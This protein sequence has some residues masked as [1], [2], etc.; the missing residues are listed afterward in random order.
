[1]NFN[2]LLKEAYFY[3]TAVA[4]D[5][6]F[7]KSVRVV[8]RYFFLMLAFASFAASFADFKSASYN[9]LPDGL[10]FLFLSLFIIIFLTE[11]FYNSFK[12]QNSRVDF[13]LAQIILKTD[14]LDVTG[15]FL[16]SDATKGLLRRLGIEKM[17]G[18]RSALLGS[19][20]KT[21]E[22]ATRSQI[23]FADYARAIYLADQSFAAFI[24]GHGVSESDYLGA[25]RWIND[26]LIEARKK[27]QWWSEVNLGAIPSLGTSLAYGV[28]YELSKY[29][30]PISKII[31]LNE[32][33]ILNQYRKKEVEQIENALVRGSGANAIIIDNDETAVLDIVAR[34][35]KKIHLGTA[36]SLLEHKI[37]LRLNW[38]ALT[39]DKKTKPDLEEELLKV[40]YECARAGNIILYIPNLPSLISEAQKTG[41][42]LPGLMEEYLVSPALHILAHATKT[43][44]YYFIEMNPGLG[45]VFER[46]ALPETDIESSMPVI[47]E[48]AK[49]IERE[50]RGA[51]FFTYP[52]LAEIAELSDRYI[53]YGEMPSK[54]LDMMEELAPW[55][56]KEGLQIILKND[57]AVFASL[58]TGQSLGEISS[59][60]SAKL[61]KLEEILH[62]RIV[63]QEEAVNAISSAMRRSRAG[64]GNPKRPIASF[65]FL[66]PTGVGKTETTKAL[67]QSYFGPPAGE[68]EKMTRFDM[69]EYNGVDAIP[70]L[71]GSMGFARAG[72]L[73]TK[74]RDNPYGVVLLDEF[75][76]AAPD[77]LNLFLR[78][79][80]EGKFTDAFGGEVSVRNSI[81]IATSNAGSDLIWNIVKNHEDVEQ[82]KD[83]IIEYLIESH[84]FKPELL[85]R[86]DA[87]I[88]F[89]PLL[90]TELRSVAQILL[91]KFIMRL[92]AEKQIELK[93]SSELLD[94]LVLHGADREFGAR[95]INRLIQEKIENAIAKKIIS[96]QVHPGSVIEIGV[97]DIL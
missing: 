6:L 86:F 69:S 25:A 77:V 38:R 90:D 95:S 73:A 36:P 54:A 35:D 67:A 94:Y 61:S 2:E 9:S 68:E 4:L 75:E 56:Q 79:L 93:P 76:K 64:I 45:Q 88:I 5:N 52:A 91:Q 43:D 29:A 62:Q 97:R 44:F 41:V 66:G 20:F 53:A 16:D 7:P 58:K 92:K 47:L 50:S 24:Q 55:A 1:M 96:K 34:L 71:L 21:E 57:V 48:R 27:E 70:R 63:G 18:E 14:D 40:L 8:L 85:N 37:I 82:K 22:G 12:F 15:G 74:L 42:N 10:F 30:E 32:V 46:L 51:L 19:S 89:K 33:N 17:S 28:A 84:A 23:N 87:I 31:A 26:D 83:S 13:T 59:S 3:K 39:A 81:F 65:L 80:D 72:E 11:A 78:V 60:E 49:Q